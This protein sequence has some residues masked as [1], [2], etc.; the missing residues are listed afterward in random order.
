M[1]SICPHIFY[2]ATITLHNPYIDILDRQ[3]VS[4]LR[5]VDASRA[6]LAQH[7]TLASSSFDITRLHPFVTVRILFRKR[8]RLCA[9]ARCPDLL[10]LSRCC[11]GPAVQV[12]YRNWRY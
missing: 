3:S 10:V 5:C 8:V 2:S 1:R 12:L 7:Y 9:N 6:I 11:P 4:T